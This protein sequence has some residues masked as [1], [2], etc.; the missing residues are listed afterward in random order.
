MEFDSL[1]KLVDDDPIFESSLLLAGNINPQIVRLQLNRWVTSGRIYQLRRGLY[2]IAPPYQ[3]TKPHPFL[4]ANHLQKASYV[5]LQSALAYYGL[6]PEVVNITTSVSTGRPEKLET[7]LG[8]FDFRHIKTDLLFGYKMTNLG[9]QSAFVATPEKAL[10]DLIYLHP[11][12]DSIDY[13][14]ELRLQ[15][16][17]ILDTSIIREFAEKFK[18]PRLQKA[19]KGILQLIAGESMEFEDL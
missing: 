18:T 13:L 4:V 16:T 5:S 8:I 19:V 12:G 2:S 15:N 6:I 14:R 11:G 10:L 17:E 1:L 9:D 7:P 3:K